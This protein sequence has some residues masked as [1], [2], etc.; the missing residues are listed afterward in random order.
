MRDNL[1]WP[2]R[3]RRRHRR[4]PFH[5]LVDVGFNEWFSLKAWGLDLSPGGIRLSLYKPLSLGE[6]VTVG[7]TVPSQ[8]QIALNAEVRNVSHSD[9]QGDC[10]AG[11]S[12][13][14][15]DN[16]D[17]EVLTI[18]LDDLIATPGAA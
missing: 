5:Q 4:A 15:P 1:C 13:L 7:L 11:L 18:L 3:E 12:W 8:V 10:V 2:I 6:R 14:N 16:H 9:S 17:V